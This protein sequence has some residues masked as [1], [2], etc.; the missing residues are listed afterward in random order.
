MTSHDLVKRALYRKRD[1]IGQTPCS[2]ERY[3]VHYICVKKYRFK[4]T[5]KDNSAIGR[6]KQQEQGIAFSCINFLSHHY[7]VIICWYCK[8]E[9]EILRQ[10][11]AFSI[12]HFTFHIP[13][14]SAFY[15]LPRITA[16]NLRYAGRNWSKSMYSW[17]GQL[18]LFSRSCL[19][20]WKPK[21]TGQKK[22]NVT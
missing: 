8:Y 22:N 9:I 13:Q 20:V 7:N 16:H 3:L 4:H 14:Y 6:R 18:C 15:P 12:P 5:C 21:H 19:W 10:R 2:Y 11:S 17:M 1:G